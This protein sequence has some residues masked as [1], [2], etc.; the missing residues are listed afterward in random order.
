M[1]SLFIVLLLSGVE[2]LT[3]GTDYMALEFQ[4]FDQTMEAG[5]RE[6]ANRE[7]CTEAAADLIQRY[8]DSKPD[9]REGQLSIMRWH[10]GQMRAEAG[11][12]EQAVALFKQTYTESDTMGWNYYVNATIAFIEQDAEALQQAH[13]QLSALPKPSG[14]NMTDADGNPVDIQWPPNLQVV[15]NLMSCFGRSYSEAY[16]DCN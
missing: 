14:M 15:E 16:G 6:V 4:E 11:Q 12:N 1:N 5:W 10:E 3:P 2:C 7:G 8:R 13:D 9:L